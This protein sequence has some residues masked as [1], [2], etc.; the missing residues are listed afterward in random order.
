MVAQFI[1]IPIC[2]TLMGHYEY[3]I[4]M[5]YKSASHQGL[6]AIFALGFNIIIRRN[7]ANCH[8]RKI[9]IPDLANLIFLVL[10]TVPFLIAIAELLPNALEIPFYLTSIFI[11]NELFLVYIISVAEACGKPHIFAFWIYW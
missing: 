8:P 4:F 3:G 10:I 7:V 1:F 6:L 2:A 11:V 5:L 9:N